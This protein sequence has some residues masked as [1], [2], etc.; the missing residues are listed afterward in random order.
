MTAYSGSES[1]ST[2]LAS[3]GVARLDEEI[4]LTA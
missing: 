3:A 2:A 1:L 4:L